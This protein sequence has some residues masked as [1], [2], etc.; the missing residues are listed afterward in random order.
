[1]QGVSKQSSIGTTKP[2][3]LSRLKSRAALGGYRP[4]TLQRVSVSQW[5]QDADLEQGLHTD[6]THSVS[7]IDL[8]DVHSMQQ[9]KSMSTSL[10]LR[11]LLQW[12]RTA[13]FLYLSFQT[14]GVVY[15]DIGTSPLYVFAS[16][17]SYAPSEQDVVGAL[18]LVIWSLSAIV[19]FKYALLVLR[20][21]DNGQG[22]FF[23]T[24]LNAE[25]DCY[26]HLLYLLRHAAGVPVLMFDS[27]ISTASVLAKLHSQ[28]S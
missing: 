26:Q 19:S 21:S 12:A 13:G 4:R 5:E 25:I 18:S 9:W 3:N 6:K 16:V 22:T 17:F 11:L 7:L 27:C 14:L 10:I 15:G 23:A 2:Q 1:M 24:L 8:I 20:A 28:Q